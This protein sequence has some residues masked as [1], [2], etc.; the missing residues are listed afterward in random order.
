MTGPA[1]SPA[2]AGAATAE[3]TVA[4]PAPELTRALEGLVA[5]AAPT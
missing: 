4:G 1:E 2:T 3:A 5:L